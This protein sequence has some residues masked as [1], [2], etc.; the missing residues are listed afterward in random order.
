MPL[1]RRSR[2][3]LDING[4]LRG[5]GGNED[6]FETGRQA[7]NRNA[8]YPGVAHPRRRIQRN[9]NAAEFRLFLVVETIEQ[10]TID[11]LTTPPAGLEFV[12]CRKTALLYGQ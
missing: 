10:L 12:K 11:L 5:F 1:A 9:G 6:R 3:R 4:P 8:V 7:R 2:L